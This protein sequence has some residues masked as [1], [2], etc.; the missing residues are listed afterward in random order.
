MRYLKLFEDH[1][2]W[3]PI[4]LE[5]YNI[6]LWGEEE[7][8]EDDDDYVELSK[9]IKN[10]REVFTDKEISYLNKK[11]G[12]ESSKQ[13]SPELVNTGKVGSELKFE[14]IIGSNDFGDFNRT[15][16]IYKL[17]DEWFYIFRLDHHSYS[18]W[19]DYMYKCDQFDGLIDCIDSF[20]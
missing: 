13:E 1:K 18:N 3:W 17:K 14:N 8:I 20:L 5:E 6:K 9:F 12:V 15:I 11:I 10:T 16:I 2:N 4:S 19:K 7:L